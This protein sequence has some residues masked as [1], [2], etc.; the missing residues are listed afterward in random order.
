MS[1]A[2]NRFKP[3]TPLTLAPIHRAV[4][5]QSGVSFCS[6]DDILRLI[7]RGLRLASHGNALDRKP[8]SSRPKQS[9]RVYTCSRPGVQKETLV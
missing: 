5:Q 8:G 4:L 2:L 7:A 9:C 6:V 3:D 1:P